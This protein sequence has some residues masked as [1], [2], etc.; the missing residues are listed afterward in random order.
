[1][2]DGTV[3]ALVDGAR[4]LIGGILGALADPLVAHAVPGLIGLVTIVKGVVQ[5]L[6]K[7]LHGESGADWPT[8]PSMTPL[9]TNTPRGPLATPGP[10]DN[11]AT[12]RGLRLENAAA[13]TLAQAGYGVEQKPRRKGLPSADYLIEGTRFDCYSPTRSR[14]RNISSE[15]AKKL[16]RNQTDRVVINLDTPDAQATVDDVRRQLH[17]YPLPGLAEAKVIAPGGAIIDIYP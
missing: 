9:P 16:L 5:G 2:L 17:D 4:T 15:I 3:G 12:K 6:R 14:V 10:N 1:M 13:R 7:L 8:T 11:D